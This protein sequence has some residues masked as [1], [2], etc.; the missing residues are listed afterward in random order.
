MQNVKWPRAAQWFWIHLR[1]AKRDR[2]HS[3][4]VR[5]GMSDRIALDVECPNGHNVGVD[6]TQEEFERKLAAGGL[7]FHCNTC[8]T[9]WTPTPAEL[10]EIRRSFAKA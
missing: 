9:T 3:G 1:T 7:E 4:E 2:N 5:C 8:D 10:E 6:F